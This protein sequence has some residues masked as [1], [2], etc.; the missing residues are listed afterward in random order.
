MVWGSTRGRSE[1]K[2]EGSGGLRGGKGGGG[3]KAFVRNLRTK[4]WTAVSNLGKGIDF[5]KC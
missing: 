3:D 4:R 5:Y 1:G 2:R